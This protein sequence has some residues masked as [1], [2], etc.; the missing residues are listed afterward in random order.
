MN[1][2]RQSTAFYT[3][4]HHELVR[5]FRIYIQVFL[6]PVITTLLY[7][8]IFGAVIGK[9]IGTINGITYSEYIAPGLVMIAVINNAYS[10]V[11]SSLFSMRFLKNIE[12]I[13]VSPI[14]YSLIL[15]GYTVGGILR[16]IIV[17]ILVILIS[18][19][20]THINLISIPMTLFVVAI[21]SSL[22]ALA[23]FT[24]GLMARNFEDVALIPTFI[25]SPLTYL[26]GVFYSIQMLPAIWQTA[27]HFNPI[28]YMIDALRYVMIGQKN[29]HFGLSMLI[30]FALLIGLTLVNL[31]MLKKGV[32]IRD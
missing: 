30:I 17:A 1:I 16:G 32:G 18:S 19:F 7:F 6:P 11:S 29:T 22:F 10:N 5:M 8:S 14:H 2:K 27:S 23:G 31:I 25:L 9:R 28:V 12:E 21:I 3:L 15:L 4:V 13:L 24:N 20:F 26:G